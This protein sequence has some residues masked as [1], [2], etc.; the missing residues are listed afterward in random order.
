[1]ERV[2]SVRKEGDLNAATI[3][4]M[5]Y[6]GAQDAAVE[7]DECSKAVLPFLKAGLKTFVPVPEH[8]DAC[9]RIRE[10]VTAA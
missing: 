10:W 2:C 4:Y 5:Y 9:A 7:L 8:A 1:M 6:S 3:A